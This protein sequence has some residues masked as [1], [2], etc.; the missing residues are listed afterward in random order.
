MV[1]VDETISWELKQD[2]QPVISPSTIGLQFEN[3]EMAG[4]RPVVVESKKQEVRDS[5]ATVAYKKEMVADHY[6]QLSISFKGGYGLIFRAYDDGAAYRFV[7]QRQEDFILRS[8]KAEFNF[9]RDY[10]LHIPFTSDLRGGERYTC[11]F[12]EFYTRSPISKIEADT[13]GYL[14]L[15][16][17]LEGGRR[18]VILEADVQNYPG[19]FVKRNLHVPHGIISHFAPYPLEEALGGHNRLNYMV[20]KRAAFIARMNANSKLPW[21]VVIVSREDRDLLNNDMVQR[22]SEPS[23][24]IDPSWIKPG[25]VAWDWWND[26]NITGVDFRAGINTET[27]KHYIDFAGDNNIEYV[28]L[29]EGWSDDWD[30]SKLNP[31]I[32]LPA[33]LEYARARNV[34]LILWATWYALSQDIEGFCAKYGAMGVKGFKVDFLDR[35]DQKMMASCYRMAAIAAKHKLLLD[36]HGMFK[37]QGMQRTWPNIVNFEGVRGMEYSKWSAD[38]RVPEYEVTI[39]FI[40]MVAGPMDYTPGAMRN[41]TR[42]N[43]K[44]SNSSP[45]SMGTRCHQLAM[46]VIYEAPLQMLAD[47]P[48]IYRKELECTDFI[49]KVP[50]TFNQTLAL[51]GLLGE[52]VVIARRAG[53]SWWVGGMT[54]WTAR[55]VELDFSFL[56]AGNFNAELF[57]DG[58]NADR[59]ATDYKRERIVVDRSA[60]IKL[61]LA[62]GG[63]FAIRISKE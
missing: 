47:N 31:A 6:N 3:G 16:V 37:P 19:M 36:F 13:L 25:K 30:L 33:L 61:H 49:A 45:V 4:V 59:D 8:E 18:A 39:P 55:D 11:S 42:G 2:G 20:T 22:L 29:D 21:R 28:V 23:K 27:Y 1:R 32:D 53:D 38:D 57:R 15:L 35:D 54:N 7:M 44:A 5:F 43:A 60:K 41:V 12:E 10:T 52:F 48:T 26:W 58:I 40:R 50:T 17:S 62:P 14:P 63:G 56:G 46:Y 34:E 9:D 51:D 24:I